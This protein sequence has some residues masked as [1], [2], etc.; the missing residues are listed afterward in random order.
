[1]TEEQKKKTFSRAVR[2]YN[3]EEV[4]KYIEYLE[5]KCEE[6]NR[7]NRELDHKLRAALRKEEDSRSGEEE[8]RNTLIL[9]KK[10]ADKIVSD[11]QSQAD[12]LYSAARDNTD[13][14][15]RE[16][17][18]QVANEAVV[19]RKLK[20]A[21][22]D[23]R[24]IIYKQYLANI[25]QL[26]SMAPKSRYE[27]E[28]LDVKVA[29]YIEAVI[30]GMKED[31]EKYSPEKE[32]LREEHPE[33]GITIGRTAEHRSGG[34]YKIASVRDTIKELNK[35]ILSD[36]PQLDEPGQT[37][38]GDKIIPPGSDVS[39]RKRPAPRKKPR[40]DDIFESDDN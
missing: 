40:K 29:D 28:L 36:D 38:D 34:K 11:A 2:G 33:S 4:D 30:E 27:Q 10:A 32:P 13:R 1:M 18:N 24:E 22:A 23:M 20:A 5:S 3:T 19:L 12:L 21:V 8:I 35:Q 14:T 9:A 25:E 39:V 16:F 15:L 6:L 17:R 7:E 26:E 37:V 31:V